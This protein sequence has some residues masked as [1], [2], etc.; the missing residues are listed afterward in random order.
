M[1]ASDLKSMPLRVVFISEL[2]GTYC[3]S[4][5]SKMQHIPETN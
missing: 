1:N 2:V 5:Y 4:S 3:H